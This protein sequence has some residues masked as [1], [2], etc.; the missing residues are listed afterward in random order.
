MRLGAASRTSSVGARAPNC[1]AGDNG[2][3]FATLASIDFNV[4]FES[5][6]PSD[7]A[8]AEIAKTFQDAR[9]S[10][11]DGYVLVKLERLLT[12]DLVTSVQARLSHA[13]APFG[14][15]CNTW[16]VLIRPAAH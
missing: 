6:P 12:Y 16:G 3:D 7:A 4:D 2:F 14:G 1:R 8:L 9:V 13:S 5:W 11:E 15:S 10:L